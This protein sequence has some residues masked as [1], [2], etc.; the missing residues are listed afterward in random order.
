MD[1]INYIYGRRAATV[2]SNKASAD[3]GMPM[4]SKKHL[5]SILITC[6]YDLPNLVRYA[7]KCIISFFCQ[8]CAYLQDSV[9]CYGGGHGDSIGVLKTLNTKWS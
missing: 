9:Y 6:E 5:T 1:I 7:K 8:Y 2:L 4:S 3:L